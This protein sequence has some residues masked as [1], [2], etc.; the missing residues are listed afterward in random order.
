VADDLFHIFIL[1]GEETGGGGDFVLQTQNVSRWNR[2]TSFCLH[3]LQFT[4]LSWIN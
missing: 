4:L 2:K 3:W 1:H